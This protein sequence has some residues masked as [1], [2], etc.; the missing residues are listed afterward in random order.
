MVGITTVF[1]TH[2]QEEALAV[3]RPRRGD[4]GR[5]ARADRPAVGALRPTAHAFVAEFVGLTNRMAGTAGGG[6]V[7]L[8]GRSVPLLAGSAD[9]GPVTALVR[10]E[11]VQLSVDPTSP[12]R[13]LAVSF[14]GSVC[15]VQVELAN[16]ELIAAQLAPGDVAA[17]EPGTHVA[18]RVMP[19]PVFAVA[20]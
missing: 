18:V 20:D 8:A 17:L 10:P 12:A 13:V 16:G 9:S 15:R 3:G 11:S 2:D 19:S 14:L 6:S 7:E 5:P 1:V 4:V